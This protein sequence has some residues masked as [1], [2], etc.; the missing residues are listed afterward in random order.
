MQ[1]NANI[2]AITKYNA[3]I[4]EYYMRHN[5][6][7]PMEGVENSLTKDD[8]LVLRVN[9]DGKWYYLGSRYSSKD[10]TTRFLSAFNG[11]NDYALV[12]IYGFNNGLLIRDL[13]AMLP[14]HVELIV[15]EPSIN[16]FTYVINNYD[17]RDLLCE[18]RL[19][20][21][22]YGINE[23]DFDILLRSKLNET[24]YKI[25]IVR[26]LP[27]YKTVFSDVYNFFYDIQKAAWDNCE[28]DM[29]SG[30]VQNRREAEHAIRNLRY[31]FDC[32]CME[33][34][35]DVFPNNL[36]VV[37]V[38]AG[39]SLEKN[40]IFLKKIKGKLLILAVDAALPYL[41][42]IDV[43]PDIAVTV[44]PT[45]DITLKTLYDDERFKDITFAVDATVTYKGLEKVALDGRKLIYA[46]ASAPYYKKVFSLGNHNIGELDNG[47]SVST[48]AMSLAMQ[49]GYKDF[50]FVGLDLSLKPNKLYAGKIND[51][52]IVPEGVIKTEGYYGEDV[53]TLPPYRLHQ[54]WF[55]M[56]IRTHPEFN[57]YNATE[58]GVRIKGS[59]QVDLCNIAEKYI[60][61][62]YNYEKII[63]SIPS[64]IHSDYMIKLYSI[65]SESITR[66][67][68]LK[69]AIEDGRNA[70]NKSI[71]LLDNG[72]S[73]TDRKVLELYNEVNK[74]FFLC[75]NIEESYFVERVIGEEQGQVLEDIYVSEDDP[76]MEYRR[77]LNKLGTYLEY[78][79]GATDDVKNMFKELLEDVNADYPG[80]QDAY[81]NSDHNNTAKDI[82]NRNCAII[83]RNC[84][85]LFEKLKGIDREEVITTEL[86]E[87]KE[88]NKIIRI[89]NNGEAQ[90]LNSPYY[91][92][93]E[94][95]RFVAQ[96]NDITDYSI[97]VMYGFGDGNIARKMI[98]SLGKN[99]LFFFYE[100]SLAIFRCA[101]NNYY[102]GDV[103]DNDRVKL[104]VNGINEYCLEEELASV[105]NES[106][107][108]HVI[109]NT[110]P[111]Y[112]QLFAEDYNQIKTR[113]DVIVSSVERN[114]STHKWASREEIENN[115]YNLKHLN[116]CYCEEGLRDIFPTEL[117]VVLIASGPSLEKNV[118]ILAR[119]KNKLLMIAVDTAMPFLMSKGIMPD[120]IVA[121]DPKISLSYFECFKDEEVILAYSS[122]LNYKVLDMM[123]NACKIVVTSTNAYYDKLL[124][125]A[126]HHMYELNNGG[127]VATVAFALAQ[128]WGYKKFVLVGQDLAIKDKQRYAG[129][130]NHEGMLESITVD[131]YYGGKVE[132]LPDLKCY[133]DWYE[134]M[135][136]TNPDFTIIDATEGGALIRGTVIQPL[137]DIE[138][139]FKNEHHDYVSY[140]TNQMP[141]FVGESYLQLN[142]YIS[143]SVDRLKNMKIK[144]INGLDMIE[145]GKKFLSSSAGIGK[146]FI[147]LN[148]KISNLLAECDEMEEI[149][150]VDVL[151]SEKQGDV[152]NN[153][154][155]QSDDPIEE[156]RRILDKLYDYI[157]DIVGAID[158][159]QEMF[160]EVVN[161]LQ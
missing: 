107:Y 28:S 73:R 99:V 142:K 87:T 47:G 137:A 93:K 154:Y 62:E 105:V 2:N 157:S 20:L 36:P 42:S 25:S 97:V 13:M 119:L 57:V 123:K 68:V 115:I 114:I 138:E 24:N 129:E 67:D 50:V 156:S 126:G 59:K 72:V 60:D 66:L 88:N 11:V 61:E 46:S 91:P 5:C 49:W 143:E 106:N 82:L 150:F 108:N 58:G 64:A 90:Y 17:I 29:I 4:K 53:Y 9:I 18:T 116:A 146:E 56:I 127:S 102:I 22:V 155:N 152:L 48:I 1:F 140:I 26:E 80:L 109:F 151:I 40:G 12:V 33:Q 113:C 144:L 85:D 147:E 6:K 153:I 14:K 84:S 98:A 120:I 111:K 159:V 65:Y 83:S 38:S 27:Q 15:F 81:Y 21:V 52:V 149:Y 75:E 139:K 161:G 34:F 71:N 41:M 89:I 101:A 32:Y 92:S 79:H 78:M 30:M 23:K 94:V 35:K 77:I 39:P 3:V 145:Y 128:S 76:D 133:L 104:Y 19:H 112:A 10:E 7:E 132:T 125:I 141:L 158:E 124:Q 135:A 63:R 122:A 51:E 8:C 43:I 134:M 130:D 100:P 45:K 131:G 70:I 74:V 117:P 95:E 16:L 44:S 110:L 160:N 121:V 136:R 37:I 31:C 148:E 103:L 118:D 54:D 86:V 55:E 69:K 96:F